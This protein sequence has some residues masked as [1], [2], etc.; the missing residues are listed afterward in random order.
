M[1]REGMLLQM[2][3]SE[4]DWLMGRGPHME[5]IAAIDDATN[6]VPWASMWMGQVTSS[7]PDKG[8]HM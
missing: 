3:T 7:P 5:L 6:K 2:D 1:P 4:H 8:E